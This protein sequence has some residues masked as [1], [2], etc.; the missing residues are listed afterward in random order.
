MTVAARRGR[1]PGGVRGS[2]SLNDDFDRILEH[3]PGSKT[4]LWFDEPD[5]G[6]EDPEVAIL[7]LISRGTGD[8]IIITGLRTFRC[9][10]ECLATIDPA[11]TD[12]YP[13]AIAGTQ[14]CA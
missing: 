9:A 4:Q 13:E 5:R 1:A 10:L 14:L 3:W 8:S 7:P 2:G 12:F 6:M 11:L